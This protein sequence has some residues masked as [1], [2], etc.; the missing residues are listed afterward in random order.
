MESLINKNMSLQSRV[1][2][3][4]SNR[5][6]TPAEAAVATAKIN[7]FVNQWTAHKLE[8][9]GFGTLLHNRFVLLAADET[10]VGVSGCSVDSSVRF[11]RELGQLFNVNFFDRW[12]VAYTKGGEVV[13]CTR[14]EF[15]KLLQSGEVD[16][17]TI[18]FNTLA[19]TKAELDSRWE[20]PYKDSWLAKLGAAT[21]GFGLTL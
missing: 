9:T 7:E 6:L 13:S 17:N 1:W 16:E 11:I 20:L 18:V 14:D 4:H 10:H 8:V 3:Y 19:Q 12:L 21:A 15:E 5:V 2:I